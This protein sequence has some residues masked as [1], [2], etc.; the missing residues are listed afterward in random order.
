MLH[1]HAYAYVSE[2][3]NFLVLKNGS[4]LAH[5]KDQHTQEEE[6]GF[7]RSIH[8]PGCLERYRKRAYAIHYELG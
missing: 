3:G 2:G 5:V 8:P 4:G 7:I 1:A 6:T